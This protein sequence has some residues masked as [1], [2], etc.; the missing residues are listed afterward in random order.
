MPLYFIPEG[1]RNI[2]KVDNR[3]K[4][5]KHTKTTRIGKINYHEIF[6]IDIMK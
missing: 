6:I 1:R 5:K 2:K 4:L 3:V